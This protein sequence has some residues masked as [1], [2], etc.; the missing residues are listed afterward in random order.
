MGIFFFFVAC[1]LAFII[2]SVIAAKLGSYLGKR[3]AKNMT[4]NNRI[5]GNDTNRI[6][7]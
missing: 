2:L 4:P 3:D 7:D 5:V 1:V 6:F